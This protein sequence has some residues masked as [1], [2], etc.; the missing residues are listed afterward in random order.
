MC[1]SHATKHLEMT[2]I[3][4]PP[5]PTFIGCYLLIKSNCWYFLRYTAVATTSANSSQVGQHEPAVSIRYSHDRMSGQDHI[6]KPSN[7]EETLTSDLAEE[8]KRAANWAGDHNDCHSTT[9]N[10]FLMS[11]GTISWFNKKQPSV[12]LSTTEAEHMALSMTSREAV[13]LRRM[14]DNPQANSQ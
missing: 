5:I 2:K 7:I 12:A 8:W 9:G 6:G 13:W 4:F 1:I 10:W 14:H 11:R 3:W